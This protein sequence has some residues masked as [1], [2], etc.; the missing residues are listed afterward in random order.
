MNFIGN[1]GTSQ[2]KRGLFFID[3][4]KKSRLFLIDEPKKRTL[5]SRDER[6]DFYILLIYQDIKN[7]D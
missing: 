2:E 6:K 5:F 3:I 4:Y 1:W 7:P